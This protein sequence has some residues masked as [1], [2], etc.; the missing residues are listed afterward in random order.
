MAGIASKNM[1]WVF[2]EM[3]MLFACVGLVFFSVKNFLFLRDLQGAEI[4]KLTDEVV[5]ANLER[6]REREK[7]LNM[8][9]DYHKVLLSKE[10]LHTH[11]S[12]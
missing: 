7:W 12:K 8:G 11:R 1:S 5:S 4:I 10:K 6:E 2:S 9:K 3:H